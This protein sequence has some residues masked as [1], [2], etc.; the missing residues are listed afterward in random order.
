MTE[1]AAWRSMR[2]RW[3]V[4]AGGIMEAGSCGRDIKAQNDRNEI[5]ERNGSSCG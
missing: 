1:R 4:K 2:G 3:T 5:N